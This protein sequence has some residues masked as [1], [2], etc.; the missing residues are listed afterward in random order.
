I[1]PGHCAPGE[2]R[3]PQ[4]GPGTDT[5]FRCCTVVTVRR[6]DRPR[7]AADDEHEDGD[8]E[9]ERQQRTDHCGEVA[10]TSDATEIGKHV[11]LQAPSLTVMLR[12]SKWLPVISAGS[13]M[14]PPL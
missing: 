14:P 1:H 5:G 8:D 11:H 2:D 10:C 9:H 7:D 13:C 4:R 6:R 3:S 12:L